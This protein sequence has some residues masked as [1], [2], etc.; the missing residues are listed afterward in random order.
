MTRE[1]K[2]EIARLNGIKSTG[3]KAEAGLA[4]CRAVPLRHGLYAVDG[5]AIPGEETETMRMLREDL[6]R[7]WAPS[8]LEECGILD[9]II[10]ISIKLRRLMA[11]STAELARAVSVR[12]ENESLVDAIASAEIAGAASNSVQAQFDR[13]I[14]TQMRMRSRLYIDLERLKKQQRRQ[15]RFIGTPEIS[16]PDVLVTADALAAP[17][18]AAETPKPDGVLEWAESELGFTADEHQAKLLTADGGRVLMLGARQVGKSTAA[19]V[20]VI[21]EAAHT[22]GCTILLASPS[23]RQSGQIMEK[24]KAFARRLCENLQPADKGCDGFRL[25]N[26]AQV[27]ALPDNEDTIRG[28]SDPHLIVVDE[29][30]FLSEESYQAL[31]PSQAVG[32]GQLILMSTP[33]EQSGFFYKQWTG[34]G[35]SWTRIAVKATDC[36]RIDQEFLETARRL[37]G[38]TQYRR[39]FECEFLAGPDQPLSL[40]IMQR[41]LRPGTVQVF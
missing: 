8:T 3:P 21:Y 10:H 39:E 31:L 18:A 12:K 22:P 16:S 2:A 29:A 17:A 5:N 26:G 1:Q 20:K 28:F 33:G 13:R 34:G 9:E 41:I 25:P 24:A 36:P 14:Q 27:V 35:E 23:G 4:K 7:N 30:A 15:Q 32:N 38:E 11:S 37:H 19:A 40:E 6:Y